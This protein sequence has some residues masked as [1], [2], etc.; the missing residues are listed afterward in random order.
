M[1][2]LAPPPGGSSQP[3]LRALDPHLLQS[4]PCICPTTIRTWV[5]LRQ[6]SESEILSHWNLGPGFTLPYQVPWIL[7]CWTQSPGPPHQTQGSH[8]TGA[9]TLDPP[10]PA[11][12]CILPA[13]PPRILPACPSL[14]PPRPPVPGSPR[15]GRSRGITQLSCMGLPD[16][17][18]FPIHG[19][20]NPA[21]KPA[22]SVACH[23]V[24]G[25]WVG[26]CGATSEVSSGAASVWDVHARC[27]VGEGG[28]ESATIPVLVQGGE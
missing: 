8:P 9:R 1:V 22:P 15:C 2:G 12:P 27:I 3:G 5:L 17:S 14:Y 19:A 21:L 24:P 23:S 6:V 7:A 26:E 11:H 4:K 25:I 13:C 28:G 16:T 20:R 18:H 10:P